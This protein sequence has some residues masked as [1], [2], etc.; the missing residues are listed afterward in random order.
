MSA[1]LRPMWKPNNVPET[2]KRGGLFS[3]CTSLDNCPRGGAAGLLSPERPKASKENIAPRRPRWSYHNRPSFSSLGCFS[4]L[5]SLPPNTSLM[6][7]PDIHGTPRNRSCSPR[8]AGVEGS[9]DV[10]HTPQAPR[11]VPPWSY[12]NVVKPVDTPMYDHCPLEYHP[13]FENL[14]RNDKITKAHIPGRPI[15]S[16]SNRPD[17]RLIEERTNE[18]IL[19]FSSRKGLPGRRAFSARVRPRPPGISD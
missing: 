2:S 17:P 11:S 4:Y 19:S 12:C 6:A 5:P 7:S 13:T 3:Y 1:V 16:Y 18:G 14:H 10:R 15:W 8:R 9:P